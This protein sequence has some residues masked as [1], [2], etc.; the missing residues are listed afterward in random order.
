MAF[1]V[2]ATPPQSPRGR[3]LGR[4]ECRQLPR[5]AQLRRKRAYHSFLGPEGEELGSQKKDFRSSENLKVLVS[6]SPKEERSRVVGRCL[7]ITSLA[8][9]KQQP[10]RMRARLLEK[11]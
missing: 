3:E 5:S 8:S 4:K 1:C 9:G 10:Y 6:E 7:D 11:P 2:T